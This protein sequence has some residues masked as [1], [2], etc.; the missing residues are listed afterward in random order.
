MDSLWQ[1][2]AV[3]VKQA[4]KPTNHRPDNLSFWGDHKDAENMKKKELHPVYCLRSKSKRRTTKMEDNTKV[5]FTTYE[6]VQTAR[7]DK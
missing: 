7:L 1:E 4:N 3:D 2:L 5:P 6:F